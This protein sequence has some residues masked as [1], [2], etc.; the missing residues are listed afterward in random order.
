MFIDDNDEY[1]VEYDAEDD[2]PD[3]AESMADGYSE[4][5]AFNMIQSAIIKDNNKL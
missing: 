4:V 2:V 3:L 5:G 1:L